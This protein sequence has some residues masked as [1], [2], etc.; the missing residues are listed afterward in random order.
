MRR[1]VCV[2]LPH[3]PITRLRRAGSPDSAAPLVAVE[4]IRGQRSLTSVGPVGEDRGLYPGQTLATARAMCP[5]LAVV[6]ADPKADATALTRL[7]AWC[8]RYTPL[9]AADPPD[10]LWLDITSCPIAEPDGGNRFARDIVVRLDVIGIP[11]RVAVAGTTGAAWAL[12]HT[13][14]GER[15]I[16][17]VAPGQERAALTGL[18][19]PALRLDPR[20]IARLRRVGL[21]RIGELLRLTRPDLTSRFGPM[22]GLR[23]DQALGS[24]E[25][26]ITWLHPPIVWQERLDFAEP[27]GTPED[28]ER[29]LAL[30]T[31]R[32]CRRLAE[33]DQG[34][35]CFLARF[36]RTDAQVPRIAVATTMPTRDAAHVGKLLREKLGGVD[37]GFGIDVATLAAEDIAPLKT[38]QDGLDGHAQAEAAGELARLLDMLSNRLGADRI[39]R[40]AP[41]ESHQPERREERIAPKIEPVSGWKE[42]PSAVR[43]IRLLRRP[44]LIEVTALLPDDPPVQFHWRRVLHRVRSATG[45]ERI[46]N[47]WWHHGASAEA[48]SMRDYYRVEDLDGAR[49][50]IF[51]TG[52]HGEDGGP[53]WY[54]H[55]LFP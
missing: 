20:I 12:A 26:A 8:E 10:S 47:E 13:V 31:E 34:A 14:L 3:W 43:P 19:L 51:R 27:I 21:R 7:A 4:T 16:C 15:R 45:P 41:H 6:E 29:V 17:V 24:A 54:L 5:D 36:Y 18:P 25:E 33:Q 1:L 48:G 32:L 50:W 39:W 28:L 30:L 53:N 11:C 46:A 35:H 49:F 22:P 44:E 38:E 40:L 37:P 55:G 23:L 2:W 52:Q 42:D 9:V